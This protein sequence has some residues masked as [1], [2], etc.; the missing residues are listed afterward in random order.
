MIDEDDL[1]GYVDDQLDPVKRLTV[2]RYLHSNPDVAQRVAVYRVQR[3]ALR[4]AYGSSAIAHL[5]SERRLPR[6]T[7]GCRRFRLI[8]WEVAAAGLLAFG[9]GAAGGWFLHAPASWD[10]PESAVALLG[11]QA[12]ASHAVYATDQ[13]HPIEVSGAALDDL[14]Q[15]LSNRLGSQLFPPDLSTLGFK[16]IGGRLLATERGNPAALFMYDDARFRR[17]SVVIRPMV[18]RSHAPQF[19]MSQNTM[20]GCGWIENGVGYAVVAEMSDSEL[21]RVAKQ[22][23][24]E[25]SKHGT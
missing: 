4:S 18:S 25:V 22:I 6:P 24:A 3:A 11:Q 20:N 16:L 9:V 10:R 23:K 14:Q 7:D 21:D 13:R 1:N 17:L 12:L 8:R 5:T 15:W 2:E 19:D